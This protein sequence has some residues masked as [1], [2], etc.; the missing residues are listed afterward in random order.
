MTKPLEKLFVGGRVLVSP[1]VVNRE[2]I[3]L[4]LLIPGYGW[5]EDAKGVKHLWK[6]DSSF[7]DATFIEA[8]YVSFL[9]HHIEIVCLWMNPDDYQ[10]YTNTAFAREA[11]T[12]GK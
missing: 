5:A 10:K 6:Y 12:V 3:S 7:P 1:Q 4:D 11:V 2:E 9:F 8:L